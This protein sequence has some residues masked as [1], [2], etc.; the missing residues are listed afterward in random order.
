MLARSDARG[1][2]SFQRKGASRI[3]RIVFLFEFAGEARKGWAMSESTPNP[4]DRRERLERIAREAPPPAENLPTPLSASSTPRQFPVAGPDFML[5]ISGLLFLYV[6]W[7][8]RSI[9]IMSDDSALHAASIRA[10]PWLAGACGAGL[11]I[12]AGLA[13]IGSRACFSVELIASVLAT[14]T[15]LGCGIIWLIEGYQQNGLLMLIFAAVN[16]HAAMN[17]FREWRRV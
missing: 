11:L 8:S 2:F 10:L 7:W 12:A 6:A 13:A 4:D 3:S 1:A 14:L 17:S 16:G 15:C 5:V 9:L